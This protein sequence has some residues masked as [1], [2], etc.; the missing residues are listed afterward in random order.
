MRNAVDAI[1]RGRASTSQ[2]RLARARRSVSAAT[3]WT[4][5]NPGAALRTGAGGA[6]LQAPAP[7][8]RSAASAALRIWRRSRAVCEAA[9]SGDDEV[10]ESAVLAAHADEVALSA[11]QGELHVGFPELAAV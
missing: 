9:T 6:E 11:L 3:F 10:R 2:R 1:S 4:G 5:G 8:P 7:A